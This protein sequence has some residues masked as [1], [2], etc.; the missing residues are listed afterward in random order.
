MTIVFSRLKWFFPLFIGG[1]EV[2]T[3]Y[4]VINQ[5]QNRTNIRRAKIKCGSTTDKFRRCLPVDSFENRQILFIRIFVI[6][7]KTLV[8]LQAAIGVVT[9]RSF[10]RTVWSCVLTLKTAKREKQPKVFCFLTAGKK[11]TD[12]I[13]RGTWTWTWQQKSHHQNAAETTGEWV[14]V[15]TN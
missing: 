9:K 14:V 7:L 3:C 13:S 2:S 4:E 1:R 11:L 10:P 6:G 12:H 15:W 5:N 8:A